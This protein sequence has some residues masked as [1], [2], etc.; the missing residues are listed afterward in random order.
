MAVLAVPPFLQFLDNN[1]EPLANGTVETFA[2]GTTTKK[3]TFTT[4]TGD[5]QASNPISLDSAGR[6][7]IW[8]NGAYKFVVKDSSG[9]VIRTTDNISSFTTITNSDNSF[10]QSFSGNGS[11]TV[12][13]LSETLGTDEKTIMVFVKASGEFDIQ[14]PSAYTLNGTTLTFN[15]APASGTNNV[16][17]F[18]PSK[19]L[20]A[21]AA[22][23]AAADTS[24]GAAGN[25]EANAATSATNADT[26]ASN[27]ATSAMASQTA[28]AQAQAIVVGTQFPAYLTTGTG[29]A[30]T[31]NDSE[32]AI[33]GS[34]SIKLRFHAVN[35]AAPTLQNTASG[36]GAIEIVNVDGRALGAGEL[37]AQS[38]Y[39]LLYDA[40]ISKWKVQSLPDADNT[41]D[42]SKIESDLSKSFNSTSYSYGTIT[43]G[44]VTLV[45]GNNISSKQR[46]VNNGAFTLV[47]PAT[48]TNLEV[49]ITNGA[50]A[51][52]ITLSGFTH[53]K[54]D[55]VTT[56]GAVFL[57][58][59][60]KNSSVVSIGINE[61]E[62]I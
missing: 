50:S 27:A 25:S 57:G 35:S 24:A 49:V 10:F 8:I 31:I 36:G 51:G 59:I 19:L 42:A 53:R 30:Y 14:N 32:L 44:T 9:N 47:A 7:T 58:S 1:G 17:V 38:S 48:E 45:T 26:S 5:V 21:A 54:G 12:F 3:P 41:I 29:A 15:T 20:G 62:P 61:M 4:A 60:S 2:A 55:F 6:A 16:F 33:T 22:S 43:S 56:N 23:A 37:A 40:L 34:A 11:Q 13:T 28:A 46:L 52:V 39:I 18:A